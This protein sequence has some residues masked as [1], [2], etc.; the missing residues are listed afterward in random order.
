MTYAVIDPQESG[1]PIT[2]HGVYL[3]ESEAQYQAALRPPAEVIKVRF[4]AW[5]RWQMRR[6]T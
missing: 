5:L 6:Q 1:K 3:T 2:Q 4:R